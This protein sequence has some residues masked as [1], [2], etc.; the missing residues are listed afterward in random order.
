MN[1]EANARW[2]VAEFGL[3]A[4]PR[5]AMAPSHRPRVPPR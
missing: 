4:N 2:Y 3:A 5:Q 1:R